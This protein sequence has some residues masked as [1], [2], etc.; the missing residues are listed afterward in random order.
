MTHTPDTARQHMLLPRSSRGRGTTRR[1]VEGATFKRRS[2]GSSTS[3]RSPSAEAARRVRMGFTLVEMM[4]T[5][6]IIGLLATVVVIN[7]LPS[8]DK[9]M[10]G[11]ARADLATL[12]NALEQYRLDMLT[13]PT[14][15]EGLSALTA[16]P[17]GS[18]RAD[19]YRTGGYIRRLPEDPWGN[20]YQY[21][22][23]S[24]HGQTFDVFS[25]GADG[26]PGGEGNDAD[27]G[28]WQG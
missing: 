10:V 8:Q 18:P 22:R 4:V 7:V 11:K 14:T 24:E 27:I 15:G 23:E 20:P 2:S 13:F 17:S 1:G 5:I 3:P 6:V 19:R 21:R 16:V 26:K 12:E 9:A 28:N 25:Y